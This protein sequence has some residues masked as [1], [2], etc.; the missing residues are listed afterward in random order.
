MLRV[1]LG[2][3]TTLGVLVVVTSF[4]AGCSA[5]GHRR[6]D[7][8]LTGLLPVAPDLRRDQHFRNAAQRRRR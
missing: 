2:T 4:L 3:L 6:Y 1:H 7:D 5:R 8:A